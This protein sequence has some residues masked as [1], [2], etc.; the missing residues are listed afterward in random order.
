M[1]RR[2]VMTWLA[3]GATLFLGGCWS[4]PSEELRYRLTVVVDTPEGERRG[5]S[6]IAVRGVKNPDW[7][8]IEGRGTRA[9]FKGEAAVVDLPGGR[10]LFALL[11][12]AGGASDAKDYPFLAF[13]SRLKNSPDLLTSM[14]L[15]LSWK[16]QKAPMP[17][18]E[19]V[20]VNGGQDVS[21]LPLLVTFADIKDPHS[22]SRVDPEEF[23]FIFGSGTRLKEILCSITD[24][25]VTFNIKDR[26]KWL[27]PFGYEKLKSSRFRPDGIPVGDFKSLF[28]VEKFR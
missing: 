3:G 13:E 8:N 2:G 5:S 12:T 22:I 26:L 27:Q 21:A 20:I 15:L 23:N 9:S 6:I 10:A 7:V 4:R 28:F 25:P 18:T 14:R 24:E 11:E 16:G 1:T 19:R 17:R